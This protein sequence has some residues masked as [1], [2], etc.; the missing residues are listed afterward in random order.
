MS[1]F[2]IFFSSALDLVVTSACYLFP[3]LP[4][5]FDQVIPLTF[6][7]QFKSNVFLC[8]FS[9]CLHFCPFPVA[10]S[11]HSLPLLAKNILFFF[12]EVP[13]I[14]LELH[15]LHCW[16]LSVYQCLPPWTPWNQEQACFF[17]PF[18]KFIERA[19]S[20]PPP[21]SSYCF[22]PLTTALVFL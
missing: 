17:V 1:L 4:Q 19:T 9:K 5:Q 2:L 10:G 15:T 20:P 22:P 14:I 11:P 16:H 21:S 8:N 3:P 18:F 12:I 7:T 13:M 6:I